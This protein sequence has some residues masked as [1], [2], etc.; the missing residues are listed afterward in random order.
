MASVLRSRGHGT[1]VEIPE[2][3]FFVAIMGSNVC[4]VHFF[5]REFKRCEIFDRHLHQISRVH[6]EARFV[7]IDATKASFFVKK[8][9]IVVLPTIL[10]FVE[11]DIVD[12]LNGFD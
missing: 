8:F 7:T 11:G 1:Y 9:K 5:K 6:T 10:C 4:I 3:E 2:K 12:R